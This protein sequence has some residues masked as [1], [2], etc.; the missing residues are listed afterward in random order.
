MESNGLEGVAMMA[1][2]PPSAPQRVGNLGA[3]QPAE[4]GST[5]LVRVD[6]GAEQQQGQD[7]ATSSSYQIQDSLQIL[8]VNT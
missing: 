5:G 1:S 3:A 2:D 7:G 6:A 4:A 8:Q